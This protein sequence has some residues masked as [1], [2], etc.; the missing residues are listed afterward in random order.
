MQDIWIWSL[1]REDP[2]EEE[3]ATHSSILAW[4]IPWTEEPRGLQSSGIKEW[5]A[6]EWARAQRNE[7]GYTCTCQRRS[8]STTQ[9]FTD[10]SSGPG[11]IMS[12]ED[13]KTVTDTHSWDTGLLFYSLIFIRATMLEGLM[14][15]GH[16]KNAGILYYYQKC[17]ICRIKLWG[18]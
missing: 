8:V 15:L 12:S 4:E 5:N 13:A 2:L 10:I 1:R 17:R 11:K 9:D 7:Q 18:S 14:L 6:T 16:M 3:M